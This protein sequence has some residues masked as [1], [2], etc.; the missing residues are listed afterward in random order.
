MASVE[1]V[2]SDA[3]TCSWRFYTCIR[4]FFLRTR[5]DNTSIW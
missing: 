5:R 1:F 3:M 2:F 4:S